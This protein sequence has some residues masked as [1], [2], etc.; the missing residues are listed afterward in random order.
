MNYTNMLQS[1]TKVL[2]ADARCDTRMAAATELW[3]EM[4]RG[5]APW[6]T[7]E[8]LSAG[9]PAAVAAETARLTTVELVSSCDGSELID[10]L[11]QSRVLP[12][13]RRNVEYGMA[14]GTLIIKPIASPAG[15]SSQFIRAG[16]FLP[17]G[18][19][20]SGNIT[21]CA[22]IDQIRKQKTVFTLLEIHTLT[23][24]GFRIE[25]RAF[26]S[27]SDSMLGSEIP[28][29]DV[30]AWADLSP[31]HEFAGIEHLPF[32]IFRVPLANTIEEDSPLGVATYSRAAELIYEADRRYSDLCWEYEAKQAAVHVASSMLD[33]DRD[34]G[35][36][37]LPAGRER[38][39]RVVNVEKGLT[40]QPF[41]DVYSPEIRSSQYLE[42]FNAQLR[43]IEF[44][45][46]LAYGTLSDPNNV[47]KTAE[48]IKASKQRSYAYVRDCQE[49]LERA[50]REW[51]DA[52]VFWA[53]LYGL[54]SAAGFDMEF[55]WGDSIISDPEAEREEDRK[56]L[57]NGTLR[58]EEYRA[59]YRDETIEEALENLPQTASVME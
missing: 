22:F 37:R 30:E 46:N 21:K 3:S 50:L 19:D 47:D 14:G 8:V 1:V 58:P 15:I 41:I 36:Y 54:D 23:R 24:D 5:R 27:E 12:E 59:K 13:L 31:M 40:D 32:G 51:G 28:L 43:L 48:E 53:R 10:G 35:K 33:Y 38:L 39:Y 6:N 17:L 29:T 57:A 55:E 45:C 11:Y 7:R 16:R 4:Y 49:A 18:Y 9:I 20:G 56:D 26:R 44:A 52:A 2:G 25:N 34:T 42:G